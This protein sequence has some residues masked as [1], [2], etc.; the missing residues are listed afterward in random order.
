MQVEEEL[1][2]P[3]GIPENQKLRFTN[4]GHASDVFN[5][6]PGDL[7][8]IIKIKLHEKF[9]RKGFDIVSEVPITVSKAIL[10]CKIKIETIHGEREI[11]IDG[12]IN[13]NSRYVIRECGAPHLYPD[14]GQLGDHIVK[15]KIIVPSGLSEQ[16]LDL[17]K[18]LKSIQE[19]S[20]DLS[21]MIS[22]ADSTPNK[23]YKV[24]GENNNGFWGWG[25]D[26]K[27]S[28][29]EEEKPKGFMDKFKTYFS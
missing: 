20:G 7:L 17:I 18:K 27:P 4:K 24:Y 28:Y 13:I 26:Q 2:I 11:E 14:E 25:K 5:A 16:Q 23:Q 6:P 21:K 29:M 19:V 10:G 9:R 12:G 8:G 15:F 22:Q 1:Q 3:K